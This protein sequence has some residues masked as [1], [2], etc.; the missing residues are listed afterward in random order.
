MTQKAKIIQIINQSQ[1][2]QNIFCSKS[3]QKLESQW[4][5]HW[6]WQGDAMKN[7][8]TTTS[9]HDHSY[10][11]DDDAVFGVNLCWLWTTQIHGVCWN[12]QWR[13]RICIGMRQKSCRSPASAFRSGLGGKQ[14]LLHFSKL[15]VQASLSNNFSI[16]TSDNK[17][18]LLERE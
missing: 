4:F 12:S 13:V 17:P 8:I 3:F 18:A 15:F 5:S 1:L 14:V 2:I 11:A 6:W 16:K 9:H 10:D 7:E